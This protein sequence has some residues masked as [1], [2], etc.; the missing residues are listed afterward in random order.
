[1]GRSFVAQSRSR[2][3][4]SER[5]LG[6]HDHARESSA[7]AASSIARESRS[8]RAVAS[9]TCRRGL[10]LHARNPGQEPTCQPVQ[11]NSEF[12]KLEP[13]LEPDAIVG[14][15]GEACFI[16]SARRTGTPEYSALTRSDSRTYNARASQ[17]SNRR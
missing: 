1:M 2:S 12:T 6:V 11:N 7:N 10:S 8:L 14:D 13:E 9:G 5:S 3:A 16:R 4:H 17:S 15:C